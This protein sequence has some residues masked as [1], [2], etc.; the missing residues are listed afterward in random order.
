MHRPHAS[1]PRA[2]TSG[3]VPIGRPIAGRGLYVLDARL[4]PVPVGVRGRAVHRRRGVARGYLDRPA[5]TAERFVPDPFSAEPGARLYRTGDLARCRPDGDARVP[6]PGRRPGEGP[7][8]PGRAGRGRGGAARRTRRPRGGGRRPRKTRRATSGWS[9]TSCRRPATAADLADLRAGCRR[10]CPTYMV[11]SAFVV[12]RRAAAVAQRQGRPRRAARARRRSRLA[13]PGRPFVA[14]RGRGRGSPGRGSRPGCSGSTGSGSDDNFFDLGA[15]SILAIQ[16]A[17]AGRARRS[18]SRSRSG[19]LRAPDGRRPRRPPCVEAP[20]AGAGAG[21]IPRARRRRGRAD[22]EDGPRSFA[23][24]GGDAGSSTCLEPGRG[25]YN[26]PAVRLPDARPARRRR[27]CGGRGAEVVRR[28][29]VLRTAFAEVDGRPVQVDRRRRRASTCRSTTWLG[30]STTAEA[31]AARRRLRDDRGGRFDLARGAAR[32]GSRLYRLGAEEHVLVGRDAPH[33]LRRLVVGRS[34][35]A[36]C[37]R[38]TRRSRRARPSPLPPLPA[39]YRDYVAWQRAWLKG[40]TLESLLAFWRDAAGGRPRA[41]AA[42]RPAP[43]GAAERPGRRVRTRAFPE[44]LAA[45]LGA[46]GRGEGATLVMTLLAGFEA[47]AVPATAGRRR[48]L[49]GRRRGP[50]VVGRRR[51]DGRPVHQHARRSAPTSTGGRSF[52]ELVAPASRRTAAR[53][54]RRYEELAVRPAGLGAGASVPRGGRRCSSDVRVRELRRP[55]SLERAGRRLGFGPV[56]VLGA[57]QVRPLTCP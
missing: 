50:A 3:P 36:R 47:A 54:V 7:G 41:G 53:G 34:W 44:A 20:G 24:A 51:G 42:D 37:W 28:H 8:L 39:Q 22:V 5:L 21:P 12:L 16:V 14:P 27:R 29:A 18:A 52:R 23:H 25:G 4:Q 17:R 55:P 11:P 10:G 1:R 45:R 32:R 43:A 40:A 38:S 56:R 6:R 48:R 2:P 31:G 35:S 13:R 26:V 9:P 33:R 57:D 15:D 30:G 49:R 19:L 46:L